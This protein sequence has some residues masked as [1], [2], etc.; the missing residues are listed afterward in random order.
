MDWVIAY[1]PYIVAVLLAI[2]ELLAVMPQ[3]KGNGIL[4]AFIKVLQKSQKG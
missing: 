3:F 1:W 4:D 2:S